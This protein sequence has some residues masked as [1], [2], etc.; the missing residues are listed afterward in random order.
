MMTNYTMTRAA[1]KMTGSDDTLIENMTYTNR[2]EGEYE[3]GDNVLFPE[4]K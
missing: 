4:E 3:N 1:I 2:T